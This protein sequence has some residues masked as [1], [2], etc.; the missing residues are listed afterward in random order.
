MAIS[1]RT[2]SSQYGHSGQRVILDACPCGYEFADGERRDAH[3]E[4]HSP[5]DFGLTESIEE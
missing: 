1:T 3:I 2:Y 5:E 4:T